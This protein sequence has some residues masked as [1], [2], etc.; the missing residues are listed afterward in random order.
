MLSGMSAEIV[1][2]LF[3]AHPGE[4]DEA[5]ELYRRRVL[6]SPAL[7]YAVSPRPQP[8]SDAYNL[9]DLRTQA[10]YANL[11]APEAM[12]LFEA[13]ALVEMAGADRD[14][15][16]D[17]FFLDDPFDASR[18][19]SQV[20]GLT[21]LVLRDPVPDD[22]A[23][24]LVTV[25]YLGAEGAEERI[26]E[27]FDQ[28]VLNCHAVAY[29]PEIGLVDAVDNP[30]LVGPLWMRDATLNLIGRGDGFFSPGKDAWS[31]W[32]LTPDTLGE[33]EDR[34]AEQ[35]GPEVVVIARA[36]AEPF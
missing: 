5:Y 31:G 36:I 28:L 16:I 15:V 32:L 7:V 10:A 35:F 8:V 23:L 21:G 6:E 25:V 1:T 19:P 20:G 29:E 17:S 2:T 13:N 14:S 12:D 18:F 30:D 26:Q 27:L 22:R 11:A 24:S 34:I 3:L 4:V 33:V 9:W